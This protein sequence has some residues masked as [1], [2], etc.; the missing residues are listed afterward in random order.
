[1]FKYFQIHLLV[2]IL[3]AYIVFEYYTYLISFL[4]FVQNVAI[5]LTPNYDCNHMLFISKNGYS[6]YKKILH[7]KKYYTK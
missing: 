3:P 1:M 4:H 7:T 6:F 5:P 2:F